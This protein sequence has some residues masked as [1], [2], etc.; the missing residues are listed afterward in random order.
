MTNEDFSELEKY[1]AKSTQVPIEILAARGARMDIRTKT[2]NMVL[3]GV[4]DASS[5][6]GVASLGYGHLELRAVARAIDEGGEPA[7]TAAQDFYNLHAS[8]LAEKLNQIA[9]LDDAVV[10]FTNSG[11]ESVEA[12]MKASQIKRGGHSWVSFLG[13]F[14][15]R[16]YGSLSLNCSKA[17]HVE[18]YSSLP[19]SYVIYA[20]CARCRVNLE[21]ENCGGGCAQ[22]LEEI[23]MRKGDNINA[24]FI[25]PI[26]GEGGYIVPHADFMKR[27][28]KICREYQVPLVSDEVQAAF[29]TGKWFAIE[30]FGVKP[31]MICMAK[32]LSGG[33]AVIGAALLS[34]DYDFTRQG[35][36][37]NT[38]GGNQIG[39]AVALKT[40]EII[41]R[42]K[43]L[44]NAK[45]R[46]REMMKILR[47]GVGDNPYVRR[48]D[49]IGM[50][51]GVELHD[52]EGKPYPKFKDDVLKKMLFEH[53]VLTLGC[54]NELTNTSL[55]IL[56]PMNIDKETAEEIANAVCESIKTVTKEY[57]QEE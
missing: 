8:R 57:E 46:G 55:R 28:A 26:Q 33:R 54:G 4:I 29:R 43:L 56:P 6:V 52:K 21:P 22:N 53:K 24:V 12:C 3:K 40:L 10:F 27:V 18:G 47:D 49:G 13:A 41:E 36:H 39:T 11:T 32:G 25:E 30:N 19:V 45:N 37:S 50:M 17:E 5:N 48:V 42:D 23:I 51:I 44:S 1:F 35:Q 14:H 38:W 31:D 16:T 20:H 15:G 34:K 2:P 9:P 7:V